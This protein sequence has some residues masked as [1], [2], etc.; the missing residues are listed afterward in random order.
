M[1]EF[2]SNNATHWPV[3]DALDLIKRHADAR[4]T[5]YPAGETLPTH[6]GLLGDWTPLVFTD[7]KASRRMVRSVYEVCTFQALRERLRCKEIWVVGAD[8]W[9]SPDEDLP[10]DFEVH[11]AAH[12]AALRKPLDPTAFIDQLQTEMRTELAALD[13][14]L[15]KLASLEIAER[16][17]N[18]PIKLTDVDATPEPRNLHRLKTEVRTPWGTVPLIDM[19]K[20]AVLRTGCLAGVTAAAGRGDLAAEVLAERLLLAIYASVISSSIYDH[21]CELLFC[22]ADGVDDAG[23]QHGPMIG[24]TRRLGVSRWLPRISAVRRSPR[25]CASASRSRLLSASSWRMR[26]VATSSRWRREASDARCR[27]GTSRCGVGCC[28]CRRRSI[29]VRRS[30]WL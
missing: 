27:S 6:K 21:G 1:L 13:A 20:E 9:R 22:D 5:Y 14:A 23:A 29:S 19:L 2:R 28:R 25:A 16:G 17:K 8:T 10:H 7:T 11:R 15:P 18:G 30:G 24:G 4:L 3:L 12:Y 26:A